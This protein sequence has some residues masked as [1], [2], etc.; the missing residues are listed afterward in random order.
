MLNKID[1]FLNNVT[2]YRLLLY[3]LGCLIIIACIFGFFGLIPYDPLMILF[4]ATVI[5]L[6]CWAVNTIFSWAYNAPV[7]LESFLITAWI[8]VLLITPPAS[9]H[10]SNFIALA[11][12]AS[13][14]AMASKYIVAIKRKH[15]FNPVAFAI[16]VTALT[17]TQSASWWVGTLYLMPFVLVGGILIVRKLRRWDLVGSFLIAA[18]VTILGALLVRGSSLVAGSQRLLIDTPLLFF[19]FV[20]LTEPLTSP[21]T[22]SLRIIYGGLVGVLFAPWIHIGSLYSTPEL[23]LIAGNIFSFAVSSKEKLMLKLQQKIKTAE[24]VY[25]FVFSLPRS[26]SFRPGQYLEWTLPH[27]K[28]DERGTRRYFT[29]AS[30]PTEDT[31]R[32]GVKFYEPSTTYKARLLSMQA[33]DAIVASQLAGDFVL[34]KDTNKKLVFIAGGI[35]I[36]PF[37]SM[38]QYLID[39]K[40]QRDIVLIYSNKTAADIA[41]REIF[42]KAATQLGVKTIFALSDRSSAP[43]SWNGYLGSVNGAMIRESIADYQ[44]RMYFISGPR[45]M[46]TSFKD[47]LKEMGI[48][49]SHIRTD[50]FPGFA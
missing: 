32:I 40:E 28:P 20:M 50:Y 45:R 5:S 29:I 26:I 41:Y 48:H 34:P 14:W 17:I 13:V 6:L 1:S 44:D 21:P 25:D 23:A 46:V 19:A 15:I 36:T 16:A 8:L 43:P 7:N 12:W 24:G 33:G 3:Y 47:T 37:R 11:G 38:I 27:L 31:L 49:R 42:D 22:R 18:G 10:D 30:A 2:M 35:G 4:S 9:L 39:T